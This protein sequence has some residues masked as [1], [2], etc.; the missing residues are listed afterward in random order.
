[1][2]GPKPSNSLM[3]CER[4]VNQPKRKSSLATIMITEPRVGDLAVTG[5]KS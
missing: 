3:H 1:M 2:L 5:V 4:R